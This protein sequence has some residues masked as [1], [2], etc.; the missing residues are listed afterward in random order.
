MIIITN[1]NTKHLSDMRIFRTAR[2]FLL[3]F[4][5]LATGHAF[6]QMA[7]TISG[8]TNPCPGNDVSFF[9]SV[10]GS[11]GTLTYTWYKN[12]TGVSSIITAPGPSV[13]VLSSFNSGDVI[14]CTVTSSTGQVANSNSLTIT[15]AQ[16]AQFTVAPSPNQV[17][18]CSGQSVKFTASS[19]LPMGSTFQWTMNGETQ[20]ATG[21]TFVT[22]AVSVSQLQS[23]TVTATTTASCVDKQSA[24]GSATNYPF[25][26][27]P[28]TYPSVTLAQNV[29]PVIEGSP[30]TFTVTSSGQG[31]FPEYQ[32]EL[33][34][35]TVQNS[36]L[37]TFTTTISS[38]S[39][40]Q[41]ISV[42]MTSSGTC[43]QN[44]AQASSQFQLV[45]SDWENLNYI[46][47]QDI[48]VAGVS[49][50][51]GVDQLPIGQ[52]RERTTYL[53]GLG[54]PIQKVDKSGSFAQ[55]QTSDMVQ[56]IVYDPAGRIA[57]Q[58]L[59]YST[60]DNPGKFKSANV[61]SEQASF[62]TNK[63]GESP[64]APTFAQTIYDNSPINRVIQ[65]FAPG[66]SWGGAGIGAVMSYD[67]NATGEYVQ[68]WSL[69][70]IGG[71]IPLTS[72]TAVYAAGTL[73]R[74]TATD[75]NGKAT[76]TYTD[77]SGNLILKKVQLADSANGLSVQSTG[78]ACTY[79]V[80]NDL[81][82]LQYTITP[83]AV[84]YLSNNGWNL[85]QQLVNDLCYVYEYDA[86]GRDI[87]KKQPGSSE[88]D[89]VYDQRD[90]PVFSQDGNGKANNQWQ[91]ITYDLLDRQTSTGMLQANITAPS[92]QGNVNTNTGNITLG[93]PPG[94][95]A[96]LVVTGQ[97]DGATE[98]VATNTIVF[99]GT[100][101]SDQEG[102]FTT[103]IN[104]NSGSIVQE[105]VAIA[106]N[107]AGAGSNIIP[108]TQTFYDDYSQATKSY[109]TAD[110]SLFDP[111]TNQ[112]ALPLPTQFDP[113]IRDRVT[114]LKVKVITQYNDLTQGNWLE[115][116]NFYDHQ[117]HVIQVLNDNSLGGT[118]I[119]TNRYDFAGKL[120]GAC[121][122]HMAGTP[123]QFT[124]VSKNSYDVLGRETDVS[125]NFNSTFFKDLASYAYDEYSKMT[126]KTLA[127]GYNGSNGNPYMEQL[128]YNYNIA[129]WLTGINQAYALSQNDY[130]QW[131]CFFGVYLG[132]ANSDNQFA[133]AQYN[134]AITGVIWR[135]QGDNAVR[136]YDYTY[137]NMGRLTRGAFNQ[138]SA[139]SGGW[140]N[141]T[142]DF[143]ENIAYGDKNGNIQNVQRKGIMPGVNQ[144][145]VIDNLQYS[146]G[147]AADPY[148]N[149]L[150]RVDELANFAGNGQLN[151]F[152]DGANPAG[153]NDY[154]YD[155]NGNLVQDQNKGITD[156][157]LGGIVYN[158]MNKPVSVTIAGKSQIQ[159]IYDATGTKISKTVTN[160]AV[161]PNTATTTTY[162]NEFV[163]QD[164][165]L[166]YV[167]HDE[168]RVNIITPVNTPQIQLNAG[169]NPAVVLSGKQGA[170]EYFIKDQLSNVRMVLTEESQTESYIATME[171]SSAADPNLGADEAKLFGQV[172]PTSGDPAV[173]NEVVLTRKTTPSS[174][175]TSNTSAYVSDLTAANGSS[176]TIGPNML[177][178]VTAGDM[179]NTATQYFYYTN[180]TTTSSN[181]VTDALTAL[182]GA[183]L[184]GGVSPLVEAN[185]ALISSNLGAT[186][187]NFASF[188]A[189]ND[190]SSGST[191]PKAFLNILFFDE[192]FNFIPGDPNAPGVGTNVIQVSAANT[193]DV[194]LIL[195]QKAPKNGWVYIYL[196]NESN[197]DVYFD[198]F[199]VSQ[200]H[201]PISEENH[202]YAFGQ[203][204]A[205]ISTVA[206]GKV[207]S[208]YHFQGNYSEEEENTGWNEFSL[209]MYDP[210][211]GRW[212]GVDPYDEFASPYIGM[213][214][215]PANTVDP[216]GGGV[217]E[218]VGSG[219]GGLIG[220]V[221]AYL[222]AKNNKLDALEIFG[223]T[224]VGTVIGASLGY[225]VGGAL[226]PS[227]WGSVVLYTKAF[228]LGLFGETGQTSVSYSAL[229][230]NG[231][232]D[233]PNIWG[234]IGS[235]NLNSSL[236]GKVVSDL[237]EIIENENIL[238][239]AI[240]GQ[241]Q[242]I[243]NQMHGITPPAAHNEI[244]M[245]V[246]VSVRVNLPLPFD[247]NMTLDQG[248][249]AWSEAT[250]DEFDFGSAVISEIRSRVNALGG[251]TISIQ[252]I[253]VTM[254]RPSNF[255]D[256]FIVNDGNFI[257]GENIGKHGLTSMKLS[258]TVG[259]R[260]KL[261]NSNNGI[262]NL[263]NQ[264]NF[265]MGMINNSFKGSPK[266]NVLTPVGG[267][268]R[269][270]IHVQGTLTQYRKITRTIRV[271]N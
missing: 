67:F 22:P 270:G 231:V 102:E 64:G 139:P 160:L 59:S 98:Y 99:E 251:G 131:N 28:V 192:Q 133:A 105:V 95:V 149:Q 172:D 259:H 121:V 174:L 239:P 71:T 159:Y 155:S 218:D 119:V 263:I 75:E 216:D 196:S 35:I 253:T 166:Q 182:T 257:G 29:S 222:I 80:Y 207:P 88:I 202:F 162:D 181:G 140:S 179:I 261:T 53:D 165:V 86:K 169:A 188:I 68:I 14:T 62:V 125:K 81:N 170:F 232:A 110:N 104:S 154:I 206:F 74:L 152:K 271:N 69:P 66:Q 123:T 97:E 143:S 269:V 200:V 23:V 258:T 43:P 85:T 146:Y 215:D 233:I 87:S 47:I 65:T 57:Q 212:T 175:W 31:F 118:D 42:S 248:L 237:P 94:A 78:W 7:V 79:Y 164:N 180:N 151:D 116:D 142:V 191:A 163:Y 220:G 229:K 249:P 50:F 106:D 10:S 204:I 15:M 101:T 34:G 185:S 219:L 93:P 252:S 210:Q 83:A 136:K 190:T 238:T 266:Q 124:V 199:S 120:W 267:S 1:S 208:K 134:G 211:L 144:G 84:D 108:L 148:V 41:N 96:N 213:G 25:S 189:K 100:Y 187:S 111:S 150:S 60:T 61:L 26:I 158:Y 73:Y 240:V 186:G 30:V 203:K 129:G 19:T 135:S 72:P 82:Q 194:N 127:P 254:Q 48:L 56:P 27:N 153:S 122:K 52:K 45:S 77:F 113:Q 32:W 91:Y 256:D 44:P 138:R 54:R 12:E 2:I 176:Q 198:N 264:G 13:L 178:K 193:Q 3:I 137:D 6:C 217:F 234:W 226:D 177:L 184:S 20:S 235:I 8:T 132:Y 5:S 126:T 51:I 245:H 36:S 236:V 24:T 115:T 70:Y 103:I 109:T 55:G 230:T 16:A 268:Y 92:L 260:D 224:A 205:G 265:I 247:D 197:E 107:P 40:I 195:Q 255:L 156:G 244:T 225:G 173:N 161:S 147:T 241:I 262:Q 183:L 246:D 9:A 49:N 157:G 90:R 21:N 18:V 89:V 171:E 63:F 117:G 11:S 221:A 33:N 250:E 58:Y 38:G 46:R 214:N 128:V 228:Y 227:N 145:V 223:S 4:L 168:G 243:D 37:T 242:Q 209:R 17:G 112:Q 114:T 39:D 76:V 201:S 130:S 141:S 167:L